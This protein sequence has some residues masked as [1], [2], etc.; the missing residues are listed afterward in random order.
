MPILLLISISVALANDIAYDD[1]ETGTFSGGTG[2][3]NA[4]T[5]SGDCVVTG[6][7]SPIGSYH[8][9][10]QSGC[11]AV[12]NFDDNTYSEVFVSFYATATSLENGEYCRYYY[13][14]GTTYHELMSLTNG[15]DDGTHDYYSFNVTQYGVSSSAGVRMYGG[16]AGA[17]YCYIDNVNIT[18][19]VGVDLNLY[20]NQN[21][22]TGETDVVIEADSSLTNTLH[23][24]SLYYPNGTSFCEANVTSPAVPN[25]VFSTTCDM[26]TLP[27]TNAYA[28]LKV[29]GQPEF[30]V[31][32]YFNVTQAQQDSTKLDIKKVYF[33]EQVLQGGSTEVF[34]VI[35]VGSN[36]TVDRITTTLTFPD[37]TQRVLG[38]EPTVNANEYRAFITDT[39]QVGITYFTI[40]VES[41]VYYDTYTNQYEVA[42]YSLDFVDAVNNVNELLS[43]PPTADILGTYYEV[44]DAGKVIAQLSNQGAP[45]N[46]ATCYVSIYYPNNQMM[47]RNQYMSYIDNSDG[48]YH[49]DLT[50]P[51]T[52]GVYPVSVACNYETYEIEYLIDTY[53]L[54]NGSVQYGNISDTYYDDDNDLHLH[55][56]PGDGTS[57]IELTY[58]FNVSGVNYQNTTDMLIYWIGECD[59]QGSVGYITFWNWNTSTWDTAETTFFHGATELSFSA[60]DPDVSH[61]INSVTTKPNHGSH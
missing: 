28:V 35:K 8:M 23:T 34:A 26:P 13:Y 29:T 61:Y 25:T 51:E 43:Q 60:L 41:G 20:T 31:T 33:S 22:L 45:V 14:D 10:G 3:N 12:R 57:Y 47:I 1:F 24:I 48:L 54:V 27:Q 9:R 53:D 40:R 17:D 46:N 56:D 19:T 36:T 50:I 5:Y 30:N 4:W 49:Y 7:S 44:G 16:L 11:D 18:G 6:L 55:A 2:W 59:S 39:Y 15:D 32:N 38:M 52:I 21:Y 37:G 42:A 58:T